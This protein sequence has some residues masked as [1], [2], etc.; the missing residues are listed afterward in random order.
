M[1]G[2]RRLLCALTLGLTL[3]SGLATAALDPVENFAKVTVSQG[4]DSV[5][6]TIVV[7]TGQGA[8]LPSTTPFSLVWWNATDYGDPSDDPAREIIRVTNRSGDTLTV[9]RAQEGTSASTHN[10]AGKTYRL[11]QSLTKAMWSQ[12]TSEISVTAGGI[13]NVQDAATY[14]DFPSAVT[15]ACGSVQT[16]RVSAVQTIASNASPS[17]NCTIWV[18]GQGQFAPNASITVTFDS[19]EQLRAD[20]RRQIFGGSGT[21]AFS[22]PG[23]IHVGWCGAIVNDGVDDAAAIARCVA[24]APSGSIVEFQAGVYRMDAELAPGTSDLHLKMMQGTTLDITNITGTGTTGVHSS[25]TVIAAIKLT[26]ARQKVTGGRLT[27]VNTV[28]SK[29][30]IGVHVHGATGTKVGGLKSDGLYAGL[31]AGNNAQDLTVQHVDLDGNGYG[32]ILGYWPTTSGAPQVSRY[33][34]LN[35]Q[36]KNSTV[37]D[38]LHL[39]SHARDGEIIGGWFN[40]NANNGIRGHVGGTR[41]SVLGAHA[42]NNT[43]TGFY[44]SYDVNTGEGANQLGYDRRLMLANN[45]ARSNVAHGFF[46]APGNYSLISSIGGVED[47]A[48]TGNIS[49]GNG[50]TGFEL[51]LVKSSVVGNLARGNSGPGFQLGSLSDV[52]LHANQAWDNGTAGTPQPG[53]FFTLAS[54]NGSTPPDNTRL[55]VVGNQAGDT[56]S[57]ASRTQSYGFDLDKITNSMVSDN[58]GENNLT[59]DWHR[60]NSH[61]GLALLQNRGMSSSG[62][63]IGSAIGKHLRGTKTWDPILLT[64]GAT[65]GT[66][67]S[68]PGASVGDAVICGHTTVTADLIQ[69]N[70][71]VSATDTVRIVLRNITGADLDISSGTLAVEVWKP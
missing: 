62:N 22:K 30:T 64:A 43:L 61:T 2:L 49:E 33:A 58:L 44:F 55:S 21:I 51:G 47:V 6:T 40:G 19:P 5:A 59:A 36:C 67:L 69:Y 11:V 34:I 65:D 12:I 35:C 4:Y 27:G 15:N 38:G 1:Q 42:D 31:W 39:A 16:L 28:S 60:T 48:L 9:T 57:G 14:A 32:A 52:S 24:M 71:Y 3:W 10:S 26:G 54:T 56:R 53:F 66:T 20:P 46:I 8:R 13:P 68:V 29:K 7:T 17:S 45:Y 18:E 50:G 37:G 70:C 23:T 63:Q 41:L 25:D